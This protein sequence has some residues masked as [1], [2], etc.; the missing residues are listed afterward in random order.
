MF[1]LQEFTVSM[2]ELGLDLTVYPKQG[3]ITLELIHLK[4]NSIVVVVTSLSIERAMATILKSLT[5]SK[6]VLNQLTSSDKLS[7]L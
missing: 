5:N 1:D 2:N 7:I 6:I 3:S 4:D